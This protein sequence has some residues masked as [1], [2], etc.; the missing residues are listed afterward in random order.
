[1]RGNTEHSSEGDEMELACIDF[2]A[3]GV[4]QSGMVRI[5][6]RSSDDDEIGND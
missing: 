4:D 2:A 5:S 6:V 1:M 3:A